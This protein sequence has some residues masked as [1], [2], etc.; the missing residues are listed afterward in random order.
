MKQLQER[1]NSLSLEKQ[2]I[3]ALYENLQQSKDEDE[4]ENSDL[5]EKLAVVKNDLKEKT[6]QYNEVRLQIVLKFV[7]KPFSFLVA[8]DSYKIRQSGFLRCLNLNE[9]DAR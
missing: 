5:K 4:Q 9:T 7:I 3:S 1:F 2:R 8:C 6:K